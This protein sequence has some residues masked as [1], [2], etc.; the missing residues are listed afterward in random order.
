MEMFDL[1]GKVAMI[2]GSSKGLG[3]VSAIALGKAGADVAICGR[4]QADIDRTVD[5]LTSMGFTCAGFILEVTT[6]AA[7]KKGVAAILDHFGHI[8]ILVN[9][10][11]V[12]H[13]VPVIEYPEEEWDRVIDTNLKGYYL[14]AK[15]VAP[16]MIERGYG[17]VINMSSILGRIGLPNQIAYASAKGGVDQM[18]KIMAIEWAKLGVRVNAIAPTYFE[19][20][21]VKQIKDDKERFD[22][23]AQRTPMGRWGK[24]EEMEGIVIFLAS[25]A[26]D[27]ITGQSIAIDGGWTAA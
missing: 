24:L 12:N 11:G 3:E 23:I 6:E 18:T 26:S 27:F 21:M 2:T 17:K 7:V 5:R 8:D 20:E 25:P 10:A 22:F 1:K 15:A 13:R 4:N 14:V 19:T 9:N 16:Q